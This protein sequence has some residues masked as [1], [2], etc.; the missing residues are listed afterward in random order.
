MIY[1]VMPD[2]RLFFADN[3]I[4]RYAIGDRTPRLQR[5]ADSST[6]MFSM[7]CQ[8]PTTNPAGY[9]RLR[10][11]SR[12]TRDATCRDLRWSTGHMPH[13]RWSDCP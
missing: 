6:F 7:R 10:A 4:Q 13:R 8:E 2:K 5:N 3:P 9:P 12:F 1:E 11:R